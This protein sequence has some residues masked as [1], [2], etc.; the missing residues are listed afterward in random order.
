MYF[1]NI[2]TEN[3]ILPNYEGLA[4]FKI[5]SQDINYYIYTH[6]DYNTKRDCRPLFDRF[7]KHPLIFWKLEI[8]YLNNIHLFDLITNLSTNKYKHSA[9][10]IGGVNYISDPAMLY[11]NN[12]FLL[13]FDKF[14]IKNHQFEKANLH[15]NIYK[16]D[17]LSKLNNGIFEHGI[18]HQNIKNN[19]VCIN[20]LNLTDKKL[21]N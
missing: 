3:L 7:K 20:L 5:F 10:S 13:N 19:N 17:L 11:N 1:T 14:N 4:T 6:T 9:Y 15:I 21:N 18:F 2:L 16:L 12:E 8:N